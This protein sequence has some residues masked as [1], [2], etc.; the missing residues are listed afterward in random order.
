MSIN[1]ELHKSTNKNK[2]YMVVIKTKDG[3]KTVHFGAKNYSDYTQH[4]DY[5]RMKRYTA[6]HIKNES[7]KKSGL[8]TAGF[9]SKHIL[10]NKPGLR[11]SIKDMEK[12]FGI[13]I[14][15]KRS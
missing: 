1:V 12:R 13:K 11:E 9:W 15:V 3:V 6:R 5:D 14:Q 2:K 8:K 10:W 4:K 7:W